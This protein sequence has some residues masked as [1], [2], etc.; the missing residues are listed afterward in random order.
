MKILPTI[1]GVKLGLVAAAAGV[2]AYTRWDV[3]DKLAA[4]GFSMFAA[5]KSVA[6]A[7]DK[8]TNGSGDSKDAKIV[9]DAQGLPVVPQSGAGLADYT[10]IR[11]QLDNMRQDVS[12]KLVRL[13]LATEK[14]DAS[15]KDSA[16]KLALIK[17]ERQLLEESV[18]KEKKVQK[19]RIEQALTF[20]EK[21]EAR[22]AAPVLEGMDRDLVLEL[23][24]RLKPKTVTKFLEAMKPKK[25]TEYMEYYSRIRSGR[26]YELLRDMKVCSTSDIP[27]TVGRTQEGDAGAPNAQGAPILEGAPIAAGASGAAS[28]VNAEGAAPA[29]GSQAPEAPAAANETAQGTP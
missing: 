11:Q 10:V 28:A 26:E 1:I 2:W 3:G 12:E 21:M 18:Q 27:E 5:K 7:S 29:S 24:K 14:F 13:K 15:R 25:A 23:F 9:L 16:D 4:S 19:E 6:G 20:I 22:K 17:Q 8:G